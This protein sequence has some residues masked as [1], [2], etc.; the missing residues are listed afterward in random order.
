M[1]VVPG[2]VW[3]SAGVAVAAVVLGTLYLFKKQIGGFPEH[4]EWTAPIEVMRSSGFPD[5]N[6]YGESD[7]QDAHGHGSHH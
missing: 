2:L 3:S 5:E 7:G 6:T 1:D 4:P